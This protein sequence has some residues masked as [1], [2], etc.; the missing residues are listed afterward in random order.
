MIE[1][2][3]KTRKRKK[4]V[5]VKKDDELVTI[6]NNGNSNGG[7]GAVEVG[8]LPPLGNFQTQ[9]AV[10]SLAQDDNETEPETSPTATPTPEAEAEAEAEADA[11][12]EAK[13]EP[14][15]S[16]VETDADTSNEAPTVQ[17]Q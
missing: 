8:A 11:Q 2:S 10:A 13:P 5:E 6:A 16:K 4:T 12:P 9:L 1:K 15:P 3:T 14:A 17:G 7:D